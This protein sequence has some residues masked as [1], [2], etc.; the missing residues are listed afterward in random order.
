MTIRFKKGLWV[1]I[2]FLLSSPAAFA[3]TLAGTIGG[4]IDPLVRFPVA[5]V[6][7]GLS[8][9]GDYSDGILTTRDEWN[10]DQPPYTSYD[11]V[12]QGWRVSSHPEVER[13]WIHNQLVCPRAGE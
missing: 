10:R 8:G 2:W 9:Q 6:L 1:A 5:E 12:P 3:C 7:K 13:R 11:A 4:P